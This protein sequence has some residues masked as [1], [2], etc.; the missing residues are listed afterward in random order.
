MIDP[1]SQAETASLDPE[2][3]REQAERLLIDPDTGWIL[4]Y[5]VMTVLAAMIA[6]LGMR[7]DSAPIVIG[8]MLV[9]PVMRPIL[10]LGFACLT[11]VD[12]AAVAR[13][14]L[15]LA[16]T[17]VG[18]VGIGWLM[19][20][21]V[22]STEVVLA[23]EVISRTA[24]DVRDLVVALAA[25]AVGAYAILRPRVAD[26]IPGVAIAVALVP[27][28]VA[29]GI[30]L[31]E[32]APTQAAGAMLLYAANLVAIT[33]GTVVTVLGLR[34]LGERP[35]EL[36]LRRLAGSVLV[37]GVLAGALGVPLF[38][39]FQRAVDEARTERDQVSQSATQTRLQDA[40][41]LELERW[42]GGSEQ[43]NL[44]VVSVEV[45]LR[46]TADRTT[47]SVV[48]L[49]GTGAYVP[50]L[51]EL[52]NDLAEALDRS[53]LLNLRLVAVA[54]EVSSRFEVEPNPTA[55]EDALLRTVMEDA[56]AEWSQARSDVQIIDVSTPTPQRLRVTI[57]VGGESPPL[58]E[59]NRLL[60][61]RL[62]QV[63]VYDL[64]VADL[65]A[66]PRMAT[67]AVAEQPISVTIDG[68]PVDVN[69]ACELTQA[70]ASYRIT[71]AGLS[72]MAGPGR[73]TINSGTIE[74]TT[75][76][77]VVA[78]DSLIQARFERD[79]TG[80]SDVEITI[81]GTVFAC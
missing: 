40:A 34:R 6:A 4:N 56:A 8:A 80:I 44:G 63:P 2:R 1:S 52:E 22:P 35:F 16:T 46:K 5:G 11:V 36:S 77:I 29:A 69:D 15:V 14:L 53:V 71:A 50:P 43:P 60:A 64:I 32:S 17:S 18:L 25:G 54:D 28:P 67:R 45:P 72:M 81:T 37:A 26:T 9:A 57:A 70:P 66:G 31:G 79:T 61:D 7:L 30:A 13:L 48:L 58:D 55:Q 21:V 51:G 62:G 39:S 41:T 12:R 23:G 42:I 68:R 73:I 47:V 38:A 76:T 59:L 33:L 27:P 78:T 74:A 3:R 65:I 49:G 75:E 19:T 24:P 20:I 10:G